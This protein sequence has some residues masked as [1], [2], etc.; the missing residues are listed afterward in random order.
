M[1]QRSSLIRVSRERL[2]SGCQGSVQDA[3]IRHSQA[4]FGAQTSERGAGAR[5]DREFLDLELG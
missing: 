1:S 5:L 4:R 2:R 3:A